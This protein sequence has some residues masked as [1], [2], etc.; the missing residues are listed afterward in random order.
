[1]KLSEYIEVLKNSL[2]KHGDLPVV[3]TES[4]YYSGG[5]FAN[6]YNE[7]EIYVENKYDRKTKTEIKQPPVLSLGHSHQSY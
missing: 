6:L 5:D 7:P 3:M 1:M 4:G 2:E